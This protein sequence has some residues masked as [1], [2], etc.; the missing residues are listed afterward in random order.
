MRIGPF[1]L[2]FSDANLPLVWMFET[3]SQPPKPCSYRAYF[4][5]RITYLQRIQSLTSCL[6][7]HCYDRF[8]PSWAYPNFGNKSVDTFARPCLETARIFQV[9]TDL[10]PLETYYVP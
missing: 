2:C 7:V 1:L 5:K 4:P 3:D 10:S 6:S 9:P 8:E